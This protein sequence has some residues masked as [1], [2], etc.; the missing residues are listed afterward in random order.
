MVCEVNG[1][2]SLLSTTSVSEAAGDYLLH[3]CISQILLRGLFNRH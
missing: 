2:T 1:N 3:S